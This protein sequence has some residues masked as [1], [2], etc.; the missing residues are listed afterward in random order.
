[1]RERPDSTE[2]FVT[3]LRYYR[4]YGADRLLPACLAYNV[5]NNKIQNSML[6]KRNRKSGTVTY[7]ANT[8]N[9][10]IQQRLQPLPSSVDGT[11]AVLSPINTMHSELTYN[12][13]LLA[14]KMT[15]RFLYVV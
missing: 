9:S 5:G 13:L 11:G 10:P 4:S 3:G 7:I 12:T 14:N 8:H 1:M 2:G 15:E 6:F